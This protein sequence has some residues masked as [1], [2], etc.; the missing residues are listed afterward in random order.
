LLNDRGGVARSRVVQ[1]LKRGVYLYKVVRED[2]PARGLYESDRLVEPDA[3]IEL[4]DGRAVVVG[5]VHPQSTLEG[6]LLV[7]AAACVNGEVAG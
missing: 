7:R 6:I 1:H 3:V 5:V 2:E 4:G